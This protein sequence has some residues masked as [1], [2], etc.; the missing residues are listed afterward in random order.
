MPYESK[1]IAIWESGW[2]SPFR[3]TMCER[4]QS[5]ADEGRSITDTVIWSSVASQ[6]HEH[7]QQSSSQ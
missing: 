5:A 6:S 7:G 2:S 1:P 4:A 3:K